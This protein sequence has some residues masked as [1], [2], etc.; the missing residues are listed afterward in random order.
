M[1]YKRKAGAPKKRKTATKS[2]T[3]SARQQGALK[4]HEEHHTPAHM[5]FMRAEMRKGSS[6]KAAHL[7]A[8]RK[9]GK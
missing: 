2:K 7:K 3:L 6:F 5:K 4:R 1:A 9:K 8:M